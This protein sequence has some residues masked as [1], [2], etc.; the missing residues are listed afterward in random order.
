[1]E[2]ST[3][4]LVDLDASFEEVAIVAAAGGAHLPGVVAFVQ[5]SQQRVADRQRA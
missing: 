4:V 2:Q 1:V 5:R 3:H